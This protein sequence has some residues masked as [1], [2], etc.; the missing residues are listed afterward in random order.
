MSLTGAMT[1]SAGDG[2]HRGHVRSWLSLWADGRIDVT[3]NLTVARAVFGA[4]YYIYS[5]LLSTS[6]DYDF[7]N[8]GF[9]PTGLPYG[10]LRKVVISQLL[11]EIKCASTA[12]C[13]YMNLCK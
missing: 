6:S 7:T 11:N 13:V 3:G 2:L 1:I 8:I 10:A 5:S 9:S 12:G 4:Y